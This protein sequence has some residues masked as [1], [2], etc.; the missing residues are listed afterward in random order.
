MQKLEKKEL[1]DIENRINQRQDLVDK[2][3][4]LIEEKE[5]NII[6]KSD[7][8]AKKEEDLANAKER[9][10]QELSKISHMSVDEAKNTMMSKL[11]DDMKLEIA[12]Y[13]KN[14]M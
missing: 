11:E 10:L 4:A 9:E 7:E 8:L 12:T 6:R 1:Q 5:N 3:A 14:I 2:R 13:I